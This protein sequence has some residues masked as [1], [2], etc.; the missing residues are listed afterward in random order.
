MSIA[1]TESGEFDDFMDGIGL[2]IKP[3]SP[4]DALMIRLKAGGCNQL[5]I[6]RYWLMTEMHHYHHRIQ[7]GITHMRKSNI[8]QDWVVVSQK[9]HAII[10]IKYYLQ[11]KYLP[12]FD[13]DRSGLGVANLDTM[14]KMVLEQD[15][16]QSMVN[17][18]HADLPKLRY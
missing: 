16:I 17:T 8:T 2:D 11:M 6:L 7:N 1:E 15:S 9:D 4:E 5:H 14:A 12:W 3:V 10:M 18:P 13:S